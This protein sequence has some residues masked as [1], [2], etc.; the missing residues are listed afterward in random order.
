MLQTIQGYF[1]DG[2]FVALKQAEIPN[3]VEVFVVVTDNPV[4]LENPK[5]D[6]TNFP[7]F[8]CAKNKGGWI[9]SDFDAPLEELSEYV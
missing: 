8:G 2:R 7:L 5:R 9:S 3:N 6:K 4:P 1:E